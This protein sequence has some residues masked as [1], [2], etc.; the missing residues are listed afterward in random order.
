VSQLKEALAAGEAAMMTTRCNSVPSA[1]P[2]LPGSTN[3]NKTTHSNHS[4]ASL[5]LATQQH[6]LDWLAAPQPATW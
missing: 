5:P 4:P 3:I 1:T 6:P 2:G